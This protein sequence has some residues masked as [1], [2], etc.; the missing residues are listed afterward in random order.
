[1]LCHGCRRSVLVVLSIIILITF[2]QLIRSGSLHEPEWIRLGNAHLFSKKVTWTDI[3]QRFPVESFTVLPSEPTTNIP[4]IQADF[5]LE[6]EEERTKREVRLNTVKE[7]LVHSWKGYKS[8]AWLQ[9]EVSPLLG[10]PKNDFG[11][12]G[13]TL[14]D[15][16]DTLWIMGL[17]DE[18][19]TAVSELGQIDF[20]SSSLHI[21][22]IFETTIR[23]LGGLLGAYDVSGHT[24]EI[25]LEK[26]IELGNMLYAAFDTPNRMPVTRW[27]WENYASG[28]EQEAESHVVLAEIG[29]LTLEFTRL[30]QLTGDYKYYDAVM[31][32][33]DI[34]Y[35]RQNQTH[36]PGLWP[37]ILD[38]RDLDFHKVTFSMAALSDSV[39]EYLPKQHLLLGGRSGQYRDMYLMA[40]KAA[41]EHLFFQPLNPNNDKMLLAGRRTGMTGWSAKQVPDCEHLSCF[42]GG[43]IALASKIF[44]HPEEL[45]VA[46]QLVDGCLWAYDSMPSGIMPERFTAVLCSG[47]AYNNCTWSQQSWHEAVRSFQNENTPSWDQPPEES[48][49]EIILRNTLPAGFVDISDPT[50]KLRPEAIESLFVLYR[51]TGHK[52]L[53][54]RAWNMF[55]KI[56]NVTRTDLA[57]ASINDVNLKQPTLYDSMESFW[58]AETLKYFYLIFSTPDV[59]SLDE[60]VLNTEAHPLLRPK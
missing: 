9:D 19:A 4:Q 29:S 23:F 34:L 38:M 8:H 58:T 1:M 6:T 56:H 5:H 54:E 27:A 32:V 45:E 18:F 20:S 46:R 26:A 39:Y 28:G 47:D 49:Q 41:K 3:P 36:V 33:T 15:S 48:P 35:E 30:S 2:L 55:Q 42:A 24:H 53:Q 50:Y 12:W 52:V 7:A 10:L 40:L 57:Y 13:A 44:Q 21:L 31:R 59:I 25:L 22:N 14:I 51:I 16:L 17:E 37:Q 60:Y 43:M 11:G